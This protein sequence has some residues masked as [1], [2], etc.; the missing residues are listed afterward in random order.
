MAEKVK[1]FM[2]F[3]NQRKLISRMDSEQKAA[4]LDAL[5]AFNDDEDVTN[6]DPLVDMAFMVI[7]DSIKRVTAFNEKQKANGS[8]GGRPAQNETKQNPEKPKITQTN[9]DESQKKPTKPENE[10]ENI[11]ILN[12][13]LTPLGESRVVKEPYSQEFET[14]WQA[15]PKK[16]GKDAAYRAWRAKKREKRLP[17]VAELVGKIDTF[18]ATDQWQRDGGQ[19]IPNPATWINQCRW[20]DE[21]VQV[22]ELEPVRVREPEPPAVNTRPVTEAD[23]TAGKAKLEALRKR[24]GATA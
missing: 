21:E 16:V 5:F 1:G 9:P 23:W 13:P 19:Y 14:F 11:N 18:K 8:K 15:Y 3:A 2:L 17:T 4:L 10:N 24:I 7:T 22:Q 6:D 12:T 20:L